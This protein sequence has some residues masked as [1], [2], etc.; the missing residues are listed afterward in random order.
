LRG[1]SIQFSGHTRGLAVDARRF[2]AD[3][4]QRD[5]DKL[6]YRSDMEKFW[7]DG[8]WYRSDEDFFTVDGLDLRSDEEKFD[9]DIHALLKDV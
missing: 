5:S 9:Q 8:Q 7:L 4:D 1:A 2:H 6:W 3:E